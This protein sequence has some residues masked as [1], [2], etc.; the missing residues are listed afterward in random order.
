MTMINETIQQHDAVAKQCDKAVTA[1]E[2]VENEFATFSTM[3]VDDFTGKQFDAHNCAVFMQ[4]YLN[5]RFPCKKKDDDVTAAKIKGIKQAINRY[6]EDT[7]KHGGLIKITTSTGKN[8]AKVKQRKVKIE[9]TSIAILELQAEQAEQD[10]KIQAERNEA[11]ERVLQAEHETEIM[12]LTPAEIVAE[13]QAHFNSHYGEYGHDISEV[14]AEW[15]YQLS[16][17]AATAKDG[18]VN[19]NPIVIKD[20]AHAVA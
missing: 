13:M 11:L 2:N 18:D 19:P 16:G 3:L 17:H 12:A 8:A 4:A 5:D 7:E 6:G 20:N 15:K 14:I 1:A 9:F 10:E